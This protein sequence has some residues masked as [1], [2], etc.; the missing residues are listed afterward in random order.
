MKINHKQ[1]TF[2]REYR[3]YSQTEL[4]SMIEG[5]SQ[6]NLSKFEKGLST[7]S[8]ELLMKIISFLDFPFEFLS[9]NIFNESG[10]AHY[11]KRTTITKKDRTNIEHSYKL[12]GY[13][14]DEMADSLMWPEFTFKTLDLEDGFTPQYVANH[15]R[16]FLGLK[17]NEPVRDICTLLEING[18][19]IVE[20]DVIE[21]FDGV[22]FVSDDDYPIIVINKNFSNDRKR[23]TIAHELGH[24]LM[25]SINN[26]AIPAHRDKMLEN[27]ANEFA[28]EFLMPKEAI[29]NS[30]YHLR[31]S[32]L[33]ELKRY[34]LTSMASIIRR[35]KDLGCISNDTYTYLNIE[36]SRKGLKKD[37][38][39]NVYIDTPELFKKGYFMHKN[40]LAY[41]DFELA[42][43]FSLPIDVIKKYCDTNRNQ[44]KLK[45][46]I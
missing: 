9:K 10:T 36:F 27:E 3:G 46:L 43:G 31:L 1:L 16:K 13:L 41:S 23:F 11:R 28:S 6:P 14:V 8:D 18:I 20:L 29:K 33:A 39:L 30:L 44:S 37:E 38:G 25:H 12:I 34:W 40:E 4:S 21:K 32:Y 19:I 2:A 42:S 5:L 26:P 35:A 22:S 7:L 15:T 17:P 24:L 45:V